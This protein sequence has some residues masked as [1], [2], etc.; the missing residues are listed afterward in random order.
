[1]LPEVRGQAGNTLCQHVDGGVQVRKRVAGVSPSPL[2]VLDALQEAGDLHSLF[3]LATIGASH[4]GLP[5]NP[6]IIH[7]HGV[8]GSAGNG[9]GPQW[10]AHA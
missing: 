8:G 6:V 7:T 1:M 3:C 5:I 2:D 4:A 9:L 10:Q